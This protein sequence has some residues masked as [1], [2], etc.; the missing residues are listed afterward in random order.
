MASQSV[1]QPACE[2]AQR[3]VC[4]SISGGAFLPAT[5]P[6]SQLFFW[7]DWFRPTLEDWVEWRSTSMGDL[8]AF[9]KAPHQLFALY[10]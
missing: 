9:C 3:L 10:I 4:Q 8:N 5:T 1:S 7:P 2:P 6:T